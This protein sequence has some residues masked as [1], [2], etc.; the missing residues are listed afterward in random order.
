MIEEKISKKNKNSI[1]DIIF[2]N[3]NNDEFLEE[4]LKSVINLRK[5]V[6][7]TNFWRSFRVKLT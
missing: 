5:H 6:T 1:V 2:P 4:A 3:Y 7:F